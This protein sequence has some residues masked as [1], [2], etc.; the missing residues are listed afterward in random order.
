M[1]KIAAVGRRDYALI[2][3][4][5]AR[6]HAGSGELSVAIHRLCGRLAD[7]DQAHIDGLL[8]TLVG[9]KSSPAEL[10][11]HRLR[12]LLNVVEG[13]QA[14][15]FSLTYR[16]AP[17][18]AVSQQRRLRRQQVTR[19][20]RQQIDQPSSDFSSSLPSPSQQRSSGQRIDNRLRLSAIRSVLAL[21]RNRRRAAGSTKAAQYLLLHALRFASCQTVWTVHASFLIETR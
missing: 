21:Y 2:A 14:G 5:P 6:R 3:V 19:V 1:S 9:Q 17:P 8:D 11:A 20:Q 18:C 12:G 4:L 10:R 15:S 13:N 16:F 7:D